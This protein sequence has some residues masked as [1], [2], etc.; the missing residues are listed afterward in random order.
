ME[1]MRKEAVMTS[2]MLTSKLLRDIR[3]CLNGWMNSLQAS[4]LRLRS[5]VPALSY[6]MTKG[7]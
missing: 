6:I 1:K 2:I 4:N 7:V 5:G 3:Y